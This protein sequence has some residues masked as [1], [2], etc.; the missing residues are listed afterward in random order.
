[1][2]KLVSLKDWLEARFEKPPSLRTARRWCENN[3]IP[4]KKIGKSWFVD[5][6][7]E[8]QQTGQKSVDD[9]VDRVLKA[10]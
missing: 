2:T 3:D 6:S 1:M 7:K 10:G 8:M 5:P 4:A 9:L